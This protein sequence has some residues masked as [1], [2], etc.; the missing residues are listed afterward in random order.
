[1]DIITRKS[2]IKKLLDPCIAI[3]KQE[4]VLQCVQETKRKILMKKVR[5]PLLEFCGSELY[6]AIQEEH[7]LDFCD[8]IQEL[9][10]EGGNVILGKMLQERLPEYFDES[11]HKATEYIAQADVWYVCDII[12]ERVFGYALL[13]WPDKTIPELK[14]LSH[15][16]SNWVVRSL[17]AGMHYAIKKGLPKTKVKTIFKL[18]LTKAA[19]TDKEIRQGIGWAAKTTAKFHPE[20]IEAFAE[21]IE[22]TTRVSNWFRRKIEIGLNRNRY[23][24][25]NNG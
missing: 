7:Q 21:S 18:L 6:R 12:G 23:A 11:L 15:Y 1:M 22:D 25:G 10:T 14:R 4:G 9:S 19:N 3:Y 16:P 20:V 17:G 2:E 5:F 8:Q 24:Q 13:H